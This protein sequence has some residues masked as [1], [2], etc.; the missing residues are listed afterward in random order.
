MFE[1]II[2][3]LII[4][5]RLNHRHNYKY[6]SNYI[7]PQNQSALFYSI[8]I[9]WVTLIDVSNLQYF[10]PWFEELLGVALRLLCAFNTVY[11]AFFL[12]QLH[13]G[14]N[15]MQIGSYLVYLR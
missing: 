3:F 6:N 4:Y 7:P 13:L 15:Y 1:K 14:H 5:S 9:A 10:D 12:Q 2:S 8:M 11:Q